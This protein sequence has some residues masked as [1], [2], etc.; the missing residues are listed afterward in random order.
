TQYNCNS[1]NGR[2]YDAIQ[3]GSF[4]IHSVSICGDRVLREMPTRNTLPFYQLRT[5]KGT[6]NISLKFV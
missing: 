4:K 2:S 1:S 5:V 6:S 3:C